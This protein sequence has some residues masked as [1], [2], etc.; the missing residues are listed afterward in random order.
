VRT[1]ILEGKETLN[2]KQNQAGLDCYYIYVGNDPISTNN[3]KCKKTT[4]EGSG[5]YTCDR[6]GKYIF[7][8][9]ASG[10]TPKRLS[11]CEIKVTWLHN[12][13]KKEPWLASFPKANSGNPNQ[14]QASSA[15]TESWVSYEEDGSC[16]VSPKSP[17]SLFQLDSPN[18]QCVAHI[19][20]AAAT[21]AQ[22]P[23][24]NSPTL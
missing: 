11:V 17:K 12:I 7:V 8:R 14:S 9:S 20:I 3:P 2:E 5:Y 1:V 6:V 21:N 13:A 16:A 10:G 23:N 18:H 24:T 19:A 4:V 22:T 15:S